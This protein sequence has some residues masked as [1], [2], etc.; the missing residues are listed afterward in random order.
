MYILCSKSCECIFASRSAVVPHPHELSST[1]NAWWFT[2]GLRRSDLSTQQ[3]N[4]QPSVFKPG[5]S[6]SR[7]GSAVICN[8]NSD[9]RFRYC[10]LLQ[11]LRSLWLSLPHY[12]K[13]AGALKQHG[14]G[15]QSSLH[16]L[17]SSANLRTSD[18]WFLGLSFSL[19]SK[20]KSHLTMYCVYGYLWSPSLLTW[21]LS[22]LR[23]FFPNLC[24][25]VSQNSMVYGFPL[26]YLGILVYVIFAFISHLH[27]WYSGLISSEL[28]PCDLTQL[29][30]WN[31]MK[32]FTNSPRNAAAKA[33]APRQT[34]LNCS[35]PQAERAA[36][37]PV[38]YCLLSITPRI[39]VIVVLYNCC[40]S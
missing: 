4:F 26:M 39:T 13:Q 1:W 21:I 30:G 23:I 33:D 38:I 35:L 10:F 7:Q 19:N 18:A 22:T 37:L 28:F 24:I 14:R 15:G 20:K 40:A 6:F 9:I 29:C 11:L 12:G 16:R 31:L 5:L 27:F 36:H 34:H 32:S 3:S 2:K 17:I 8:S 25:L